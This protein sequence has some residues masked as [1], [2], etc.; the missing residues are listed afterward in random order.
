[1]QRD[2]PFF[3]IPSSPHP[4]QAPGRPC[5]PPRLLFFSLGIEAREDG[6]AIGRGE[7]EGPE[8]AVG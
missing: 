6:R 4:F 2:P 7:T 1:M 3:P 8:S 5:N